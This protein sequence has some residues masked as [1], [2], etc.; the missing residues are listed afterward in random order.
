MSRYTISLEGAQIDLNTWTISNGRIE[1]SRAQSQ[2]PDGEVK[3][4]S[5][6]DCMNEKA[7]LQ[8][9]PSDL[10]RSEQS[11]HLRWTR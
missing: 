2:S 5:R 6:C 9:P 4:V 10:P 7:P 11:D 1:D 8:I 3:P